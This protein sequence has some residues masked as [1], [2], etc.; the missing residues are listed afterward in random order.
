MRTLLLLLALLVLAGCAD[1]TP[2]WNNDHSVWRADCSCGYSLSALPSHDV[3]ICT[4]CG[5]VWE[6]ERRYAL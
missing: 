6:V 4:N 3:I 2:A 5:L 1:S